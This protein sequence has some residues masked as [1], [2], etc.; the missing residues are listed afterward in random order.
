MGLTRGSCRLRLRGP[1]GSASRRAPRSCARREP[2]ARRHPAAAG[3]IG[4][5]RKKYPLIAL[6]RADDEG[7]D[8][9]DRMIGQLGAAEALQS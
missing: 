1:V 9:S 4:A 7:F 8:E 6:R 2:C 3:D 5:T